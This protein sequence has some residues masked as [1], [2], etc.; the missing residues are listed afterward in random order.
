M[1][2]KRYFNKMIAIGIIIILLL[3]IFMPTIVSA[4][5][6]ARASDGYFRIKDTN[7]TVSD[8]KRKY[9][10]N[11]ADLA[12]LNLYKDNTIMKDTDIVATGMTVKD[13]SANT[14]LYTIVVRGDINCDGKISATDLSQFK[15]HETSI[16]KIDGARLEAADIN[17][18]GKI[19][20]LDRSQLKM[21]LVGLSLAED[22]TTITGEIKIVPSSTEYAKEVT[23]TVAWPQDIEGL[24]KQIS[25]NNGQTFEIYTEP[26]VVKENTTVIARLINA[27]GKVVASASLELSKI[28]N[29]APE[30]FTMSMV[31]KIANF[32]TLSGSTTDKESGMGLYYFTSTNGE[33]WSP[34]AGQEN[35]TYTFMNITPA[36]TVTLKM[37]AVDKVGNETETE[38]V[39]QRTFSRGIDILNKVLN[40]VT[41]NEE[42]QTISLADGRV[43]KLSTTENGSYSIT[44][45]GTQTE[46][47]NQIEESKSINAKIKE[48]ENSGEL[49]LEQVLNKLAEDGIGATDLEEKTLTIEHLD[50]YTQYRIVQNED[51]TFTATFKDR[52]LKNGLSVSGQNAEEELLKKI[53]TVIAELKESGDISI[54]KILQKVVDEGLIASDN[55]NKNR[56]TFTTE[57]GTVY[58]VTTNPESQDEYITVLIGL[59][60]DVENQVVINQLLEELALG[61]KNEIIDWA[62]QDGITTEEKANRDEGTYEDKNGAYKKVVI[63]LDEGTYKVEDAQKTDGA[64]ITVTLTPDFPTMTNEVT[65]KIDVEYTSP[66]TKIEVITEIGEVILTETPNTNTASCELK[67]TDNGTY[68]V[69]VTTQDG[70]VTEKEITVSNISVLLPI[71]YVITPEI[72]VNTIKTGTQNGVE[73]GPISV[74]VKYSD[75][76]NLTNKD[77]YQYKK[78]ND[79]NWTTLEEGQKEVLI[80]NI[81]TNCTLYARYWD[82][83]NSIKQVSIV[84]DNV[85]NINPD[86]FEATVV[87]TTH[88]ITVSAMT[89]DVAAD[90]DGNPARDGIGGISRYEYSI[91]NGSTWQDNQIFSNLTQDTE[92]QVI[93]KAIDFAGNSTISSNSGEVVK[94]KAVPSAKDVIT[95]DYSNRELTKDSVKVTINS[96]LSDTSYVIQYQVVPTGEKPTEDNWV[97]GTTY[98][99]IQNCEI[100]VRIT[101]IVGQTSKNGEYAVAKVTNID[102]LAPVEFVPEVTKVSQTTI[103]VKASNEGNGE[104]KDAAA[105]GTS[106]SSGIESYVYYLVPTKGETVKTDA[107]NEHVYTF[108][109]LQPGSMYN[110]YVEVTDKVG[111]KRLSEIIQGVTNAKVGEIANATT[112]ITGLKSEATYNNPIIPAGFAPVD[113]GEVV[114]GDG[115]TIPSGW[116]DGLILQDRDGNQFI[117]VPVDGEDVVYEKWITSGV[118]ESK[119]EDGTLPDLGEEQTSE[120]DQIEKYNGYYIGRFES[121]KLGSK[122]GSKMGENAWTAIRY[123]TAKNKAEKMYQTTSVQSGL[124]T[125]KQWDT[126]MRWIATEKG[127]SY[128]ATD[129]TWGN[130]TNTKQVTGSN[131]AWK[132]KNI[133]DLA[134][135]VQEITNE[136]Y[137]GNVVARG[138]AYNQIGVALTRNNFTKEQTNPNLGFRTVL[139]VVDADEYIP[140]GDGVLGIGNINKGP[141]N[142]AVNGLEGSYLNPVVPVG[143]MAVNTDNAKW[144]GITPTGWNNGLV[145]EDVNGN[146]FVWIPVNNIDVTYEKWYTIFAPNTITAD[147]IAGDEIPTALE[148]LEEEEIAQIERYGGFYIGRYEAGN[149][150]GTLASKSGMRTVNGVT[151]EEAKT[152]AEAMYN[153]PYVKSG[154]LTGT[155]WDTTMR[156][157]A[158]EY[159]ES[160]VTNNRATGNNP[161]VTFS[162]SGDYAKGPNEPGELRGA[163]ELGN[164]VFKYAGQKFLIATGLVESFKMKNI[165]DLAGNVWEYT[166]EYTMNL[167]VKEAIA[168]G[169]DYYRE[170]DQTEAWGAAIRENVSESQG[171]KRNEGGFR[172]ALF[173]TEGAAEIGKFEDYNRTINGKPASYDNPVIPAGF[174]PVEKG[175]SWG[176][177]VTIPADWNNGLVIEDEAGNQFVWVPVNDTDVRYDKWA[178]RGISYKETDEDEIPALVEAWGETEETQINKYGGFYIARYESSQADDGTAQTK[179]GVNAWVSIN[180]NQAKMA[181]ESMPTKEKVK[182]GLITGTQWDTV[183]KWISGESTIGESGVIS[184][185]T[186]WGNYSNSNLG[187]S[188]KAKNIFEL[189][190]GNWEWTTESYGENKIYRGG[191]STD[192]GSDSPAA[193][194]GAYEKEKVDDATTFRMVLYVT[195]DVIGMATHPV[196]ESEPLPGTVFFE[197]VNAPEL[198]EGMIPV[199]WNG[200]TWVITTPDD[201]NWY[202]YA[203]VTEKGKNT[204]RWANA[205]T[206]DGSMWVWIPR[207]AYKI[208]YNNINNK[209]AGGS[210][211]VVFLG[212]DTNYPARGN[213]KIYAKQDLANNITTAN[214]YIVHPSFTSDP[215]I[216]GWDKELTGIWVAKFETSGTTTGYKLTSKPNAISYSHRTASVQFEAIQKA[217]FGMTTEQKSK[218]DSHMAKNSD[219]GAI[220]YLAYSQYGRN[221]EKI[222]EEYAWSYTVRKFLY[223]STNQNND[224][225]PHYRT[226]KITEYITGGSALTPD[227][228]NDTV[229]YEKRPQRSTTGNV[230]GIYDMVGLREEYVAAYNKAVADLFVSGSGSVW[231]IREAGT[232]GMDVRY[233]NMAKI[234][235][236]A[237]KYRQAYTDTSNFYGDAKDETP[238]WEGARNTYTTVQSAIDGHGGRPVFSRGLSTTTSYNE[239]ST[240]T[241]SIF[242]AQ[243]NC[244]NSNIGLSSRMIIVIK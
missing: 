200:S 162:F 142:Q 61:L 198:S 44:S 216:G 243:L 170:Y 147:Q 168:R 26:V 21:L 48:Y 25:I 222:E 60:E 153:T 50:Y 130:Y 84:V 70:K 86:E 76:P 124:V 152:H 209:S 98:E 134:G 181:A 67:L 62:I 20:V 95:F 185:S 109:G 32:I 196:Q 239:E 164:E 41:V 143:F 210:I 24:T 235:Q 33:Q 131:E 94:T 224:Q 213:K 113:E 23:I 57:I 15:M 148:E 81:T 189:A 137:D 195:G 206:P 71:K 46:S 165:Y 87:S 158:T 6:E 119:L 104:A 211:D 100:Y 169:A 77:K 54:S 78:E 238:G 112:T 29:I 136:L 221:G 146:Q 132:V 18:D 229:T 218:I 88:S 178:E 123:E 174:A 225:I 36:S 56:G 75:A 117:W 111:N 161:D 91:D 49:T 205:M 96:N 232:S 108:E 190:G 55:V 180:Y 116:N 59:A 11:I 228:T 234:T 30:A 68:T 106:A 43:Y 101:D 166:S 156:W 58:A 53:D 203:D 217:K 241:S 240:R 191:V 128:V 127:E 17:Y 34:R 47:T 172:V 65:A 154:L 129:V 66:I 215:A 38:S 163:Y 110:I 93:V 102:N 199:K 7:L 150:D 69:K 107:I 237:T 219:W 173:L 40:G 28:D 10:D 244:A 242:T 72:P 227:I 5:N 236:A 187:R 103:T 99:T 184:D 231:V 83:Q 37:K 42:E 118:N 167:E 183:M 201:E 212:E 120:E 51:G 140:Q 52:I 145:I 85:D 207:Y 214:N 39:T 179:E 135:N 138:G 92:Y 208:N 2:D 204:S 80:E 63:D 12:N 220:A 90:S 73:A 19:S 125:G 202:D 1:E 31:H 82:G 223:Y 230:Y 115:T 79:E 182:S 141:A 3:Q 16:Q 171:L 126:L 14:V 177:G 139:Y 192:A 89:T 122:V 233:D 35:G 144:T 157:I 160:R 74:T 64:K 197:E 27:S 149:E 45:V 114:W 105:T 194:R 155:M 13:A 121:S 4:A 8:F 188:A 133:Y 9:A 97:N 193:Y 176:N 175:A 22:E 159:G 151:Y 186:S 226:Y